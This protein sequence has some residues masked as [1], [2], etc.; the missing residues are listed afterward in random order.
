[1]RNRKYNQ[2]VFINDGKQ[3]ASW[4]AM[5]ENTAEGREWLKKF[6]KDNPD[7]YIKARGRHSDRKFVYTEL[8]GRKYYSCSFQHDIPQ[9]YA[10]RLAIYTEKKDWLSKLRHARRNYA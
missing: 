4:Y 10:Q 9:M 5:I 6:R 2:T 3:G 8:M 1:M 7:L